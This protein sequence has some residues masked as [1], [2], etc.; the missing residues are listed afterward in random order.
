MRSGL[1]ASARSGRHHPRLRRSRQIARSVL[2]LSDLRSARKALLASETLSSEEK[3]LIS[4]VPLRIHPCDDMYRRGT[5]RHYLSIGLSARRCIMAVLAHARQ[6]TIRTILDLPSGYGR[7]LRFLQLSFPNGRVWAC[8]IVPEAVNF[9]T[10]QFNVDAV[11][12]DTDFN[13]ISFQ[14][15]FDL[16][17]S[18]SLLTHLDLK[19]ATELLRLFH[20]SL[21]PT[22]VCVFTMHGQTSAAWLDS[23]NETYGLPETDVQKVLSDFANEG[24]GYVNYSEHFGYG[25][26]LATR[27]R[28][29]Q[30]ASEVGDWNFLS[31]RESAWTDHHDVYAFS[32]GPAI[33]PLV[34]EARGPIPPP[35][36]YQWVL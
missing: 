24:Y 20:R 9:C 7:I 1:L 19:N 26:A 11:V 34:H 8:D 23:R 31:F 29:V 28:I 36:L 2:S 32:N 16:I 27:A 6:N 13:K 3:G 22:G 21:S 30:M 15:N 18:G 35:N 4:R 25:I 10:K 5:G 33:T 14:T 12:S 17:W